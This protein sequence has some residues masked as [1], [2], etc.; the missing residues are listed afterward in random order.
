[1]PNAGSA[2]LTSA[3]ER[4]RPP[5]DPDV[6]RALEAQKHAVVTSMGAGDVTALRAASSCPDESA[7]T[8]SGEFELTHHEA[9]GADGRTVRMV[10]LR[11]RDRPVTVPIIYHVHGGGM[12]VGSAYD[13]LPQM[14]ELASEVGAAVASVEYRL[15]PEHPYP[16]AIED[17]Y[18]GLVWLS[19]DAASLGL[20]PARVIVHGVSAGGGL[21]AGC[22]LL[23][24][25]RNGPELLG[26]MLIYPMLDDRNDSDSARQ[27]AGAGAWDR[28]ANATGWSLYLGDR[29][30]D[31]VPIYA[32][33]ARA[34]DLS[35]L[36]PTFIDV[37]SAE[38]FRDEDIAYASR[39]WACGG[40][41]EL[42]VWPGGAH[43][44]D[45]LAPEAALS[46]D[47]RNARVRWLTRLLTRP[48]S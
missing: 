3:D 42:H 16:A 23:A 46:S 45:T 5:F 19:T 9:M 34:D 21:A 12:V 30:R 8:R 27:M 10:L 13:I 39:M 24:R 32:A 11:P 6:E 44:F 38:T 36:P 22:A 4:P 29:A 26:Q 43:G 37:G 28:T 47:A 25:D 18:T 14:A 15:A 31:D 17:V 35:N 48:L 41:A 40:D 2:V 20:D 33:P 1:M 7:L